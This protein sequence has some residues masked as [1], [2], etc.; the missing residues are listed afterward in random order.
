MHRLK[1][2]VLCLVFGAAA[3]GLYPGFDGGPR[4][5]RAAGTDF[6]YFNW[7]GLEGCWSDCAEGAVCCRLVYLVEE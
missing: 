6:L 7:W 2:L 3:V 4:S 5:L 1:K